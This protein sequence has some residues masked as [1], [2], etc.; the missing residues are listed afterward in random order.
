MINHP[1]KTLRSTWLILF[2]KKSKM[3]SFSIS[4]EFE[5]LGKWLSIDSDKM[6]VNKPSHINCL[7]DLFSYIINITS[8]IFY[9]EFKSFAFL[10]YQL[11]RNWFWEQLFKCFNLFM[12]FLSRIDED[13]IDM[14]FSF[15][16]ANTLHIFKITWRLV[17]KMSC[18]FEKVTLHTVISVKPNEYW[19]L[20]DLICLGFQ[21]VL[22]ISLSAKF[23]TESVSLPIR[24]KIPFHNKSVF[25]NH[26]NKAR[27]SILFIVLANKDIF[28]LDSFI[29][30]IDSRHISG[31]EWFIRYLDKFGLR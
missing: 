13:I 29:Y 26:S 7:M 24:G 27:W 1:Y 16:I 18:I 2:S 12:N 4:K 22:N 10:I 25:I 3:D 11:V 21:F 8:M 28:T 6:I 31:S 23:D 5:F 14:I 20:P 17:F 30:H 19:R 15:Y 9:S